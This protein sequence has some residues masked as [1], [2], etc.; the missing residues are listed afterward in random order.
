M[1]SRSPFAAPLSRLAHAAE[2]VGWRR[3]P[4]VALRWTLR[5]EFL[6]TARDLSQPLPEIPRD[7][8]EEWAAAEPAD[9][10]A[11]LEV[12]PTSSARELDRR[13][14][15]GQTCRVCRVEGRAVHWRWQITGPAHLWY[16]GCSLTPAAGDWII[17]EV[18]TRPDERSAG[19][20]S[21]SAIRAL[22]EA[23]EADCRRLVG[24]VAYWNRPAIRVMRE[25]SGREVIGRLGYRRTLSAVAL[26]PG[27]TP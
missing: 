18:L 4:G 6:I 20:Y 22:H 24:F 10:E 15:D 14:E 7:P 1:R 12:D 23:R 8:R 11:L 17:T 21:R 16:L 19:V 26:G 27:T 5:R 13:I 9:L 25:V 3:L 2:C